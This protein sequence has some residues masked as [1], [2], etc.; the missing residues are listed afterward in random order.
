MISYFIEYWLSIFHVKKTYILSGPAK[1]RKYTAHIHSHILIFF[2]VYYLRA[3]TLPPQFYP[4][5]YNFKSFLN[6][7][8]VLQFSTQISDKNE[9]R[10]IDVS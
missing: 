1:G 6:F 3:S 2:L 8:Q 10:F 9:F 5:I 4:C 7:G